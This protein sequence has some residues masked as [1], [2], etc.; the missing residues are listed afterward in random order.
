MNEAQQERLAVEVADEV[1]AKCEIAANEEE[2]HEVLRLL[3]SEERERLVALQGLLAVANQPTYLKRQ[4]AVAE[5]LGISVRSV[6]R[7]VR[8]LREEGASN[9][10]R[11]SRSDRGAARISE[12]WQDFIVKTY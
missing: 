7:L 12:S 3:T 5:Q 6:R 10:I 11:R 4:Q 9:V 2:F 1:I 8:Q